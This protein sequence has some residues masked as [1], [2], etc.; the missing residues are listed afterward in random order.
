MKHLIYSSEHVCALIK[1][2]TDT[3]EVVRIGNTYLGGK[4]FAS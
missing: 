4:W 1:G 2:M 3:E